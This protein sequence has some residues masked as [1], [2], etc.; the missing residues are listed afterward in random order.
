MLLLACATVYISTTGVETDPW[1]TFPRPTASSSCG[2]FGVC[3]L[4]IGPSSFPLQLKVSKRERTN[5]TKLEFAEMFFGSED[6]SV[7]PLPKVE[8]CGRMYRRYAPHIHESEIALHEEI[9]L[10]DKRL[11]GMLIR[12][13]IRDPALEF[14]NLSAHDRWGRGHFSDITFGGVIQVAFGPHGDSPNDTIGVIRRGKTHRL[15]M[16]GSEVYDGIDLV[17]SEDCRKLHANFVT[18]EQV[19]REHSG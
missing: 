8:V 10:D 2:Q 5:E 13:C 9:Q 3:Q 1:L 14:E 6:W 19:R 16:L 15:C 11:Y 4:Q 17:V 18:H 7:A 12:V